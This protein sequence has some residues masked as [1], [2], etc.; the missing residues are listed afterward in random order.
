M[1]FALPK[2]FSPIFCLRLMALGPHC[3]SFG[4][5]FGTFGITFGDLGG[6]L[7]PPWGTLGPRPLKIIKKITFGDLILGSVFAHFSLFRDMFFK[8]KSEALR[9][10]FVCDFCFIWGAQL[11]VIRSEGSETHSGIAV[12]RRRNWFGAQCREGG[13]GSGLWTRKVELVPG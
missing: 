4:L 8:S 12:Q 1:I 13:I 7:G 9:I 3:G 6:S 5:T 2:Q 10:T 11:S